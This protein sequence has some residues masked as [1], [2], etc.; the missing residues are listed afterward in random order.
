VAIGELEIALHAHGV[1]FGIAL[2][3]PP[4]HL[5]VRA[6]THRAHSAV[7]PLDQQ[8]ELRWACLAHLA[9]VELA[10]VRH[11]VLHRQ[12]FEVFALLF[13]L[14]RLYHGLLR[15]LSLLTALPTRVELESAWD[16]GRLIQIFG[17]SRA[18]QGLLRCGYETTA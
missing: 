16:Q 1:H 12:V 8:V 18:A 15:R 17:R 14:G 5:A 2:A 11:S 4:L 6:D 7:V 9:L 3:Q 10:L 13:V